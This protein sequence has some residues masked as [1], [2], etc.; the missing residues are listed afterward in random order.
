MQANYSKP[1]KQRDGPPSTLWVT[2]SP[3]K[4]AVWPPIPLKGPGLRRSRDAPL[5]Q[6][7]EAHEKAVHCRARSLP[8]GPA[9]QPRSVLVS[10]KD[11]LNS[12]IRSLCDVW[13][14]GL[15]AWSR[16]T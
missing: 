1:L 7:A 13:V 11:S 9:P 4:A 14:E 8:G 15:A 5:Q 12:P 6:T 16:D 10:H 2:F 3:V